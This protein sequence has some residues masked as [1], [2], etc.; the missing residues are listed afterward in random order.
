MSVFGSTIECSST[1]PEKM[2]LLVRLILPNQKDSL[3]IDSAEVQW[4]KK[5]QVG[6]QFNKLERTANL[7]LHGFG[8]DRMVERVHAIQQQRTTS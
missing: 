2:N 3:P 6:L 7:R 8:W 4:V 5:A 1:V